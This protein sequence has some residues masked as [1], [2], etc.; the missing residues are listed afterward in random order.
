[1]Y[2]KIFRIVSLVLILCIGGNVNAFECLS[3]T[4]LHTFIARQC[5]FLNIVSAQ[6]ARDTASCIQWYLMQERTSGCLDHHRRY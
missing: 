5:D 2:K 1:M 3:P 4:Q 6:H